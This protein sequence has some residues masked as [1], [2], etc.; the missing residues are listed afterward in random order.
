[1][2]LAGQSGE[3]DQEV[4][5]TMSAALIDSLFEAHS[6]LITGVVF[7]A[8]AGVM[9]GLKTGESLIWACVVLFVAAGAIRAFDLHRY[10]MRKSGMTAEE[11]SQWKKRYQIGAMVQAA[12]IGLWCSTTLLSSDD[13]IAHMICL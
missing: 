3:R 10:Q 8:V 6:P 7:S 12:A 13:A 1:M 4:S 11:A 2:Q 5:P 9:T